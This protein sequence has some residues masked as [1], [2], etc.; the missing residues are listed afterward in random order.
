MFGIVEFAVTTIKA[1]ED[2]I[3]EL[4]RSVCNKCGSNHVEIGKRCRGCGAGRVE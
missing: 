2:R 1:M 4:E 3:E